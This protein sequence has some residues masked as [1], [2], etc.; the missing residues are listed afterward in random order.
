MAKTRSASDLKLSGSTL[1]TRFSIS[2]SI[3]LTIV[4]IGAGAFLYS[5]ILKKA[6]QI[7]EQAFVGAVAFQGPW[8]ERYY[9]DIRREI[10]GMQRREG[11]TEAAQPIQG[12][13]QEFAGHVRQTVL[14]SEIAS[15][16][17]SSQ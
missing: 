6:D 12:T 7:Q 10:S 9:D 8:Q 15:S 11:S 5:W 14:T 1:G 2:M 4:M 3:A 16:R 17:C 13:T